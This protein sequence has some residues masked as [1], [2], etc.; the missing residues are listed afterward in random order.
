M[1]SI[2][3]WIL[4]SLLLVSWCLLLLPFYPYGDYIPKITTGSFIIIVASSY[5]YGAYM[6]YILVDFLRRIMVDNFKYAVV[7]LPIEYSGNYVYQLIVYLSY[8]QV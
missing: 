3:Y 2:N 8:L 7:D 5:Y 4:F 6:H 1:V